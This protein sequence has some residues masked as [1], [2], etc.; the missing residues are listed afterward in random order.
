MQTSTFCLLLTTTST[1]YWVKT[2]FGYF[3]VLRKLLLFSYYFL[4]WISFFGFFNLLPIFLQVLMH[5]SVSASASERVGIR[6]SNSFHA[7]C[8]RIQETL[9]FWIHSVDSGF[10]VL[11][12]SLC[13]W[14]SIPQLDS[15]FL[16]V[17]SRFQSPGFRI[18]QAKI[19]RFL[20]SEFL[21]WDDP[22]KT[23]MFIKDVYRLR[24][25]QSTRPVSL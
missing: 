6:L 19:S 9:G 22:S 13:Q 8:K 17:Y 14:K 25:L 2:P 21:K 15:V 5:V 16:E 24:N 12:S 18:P 23:R 4:R 7:P 20:E 1:S 3:L 10:Q 11:D